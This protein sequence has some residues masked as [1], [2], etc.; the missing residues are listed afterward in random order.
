MVPAGW[1]MY[2][3]CIFGSE[4][5]EDTKKTL[6]LKFYIFMSNFSR[7]LTIK[8]YLILSTC[9]LVD[10]LTCGRTGHGLVLWWCR[11]PRLVH[12]DVVHR[13]TLHRTSGAEG[14]RVAGWSSGLVHHP[15][16][17]IGRQRLHLHDS[18]FTHQPSILFQWQNIHIGLSSDC[19]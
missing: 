17:H 6:Q 11:L 3:L 4:R 12:I 5:R 13:R 2:A 19:R 1:Y 18:T 16:C 14:S 15:S 9:L 8:T 7:K 10:L